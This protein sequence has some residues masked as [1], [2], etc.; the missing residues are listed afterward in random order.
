MDNILL[1]NDATEISTAISETYC[2]LEGNFSGPLN[3][4]SGINDGFLIQKGDKQTGLFV[5]NSYVGY[6][7]NNLLFNYSNTDVCLSLSDTKSFFIGGN[8]S[9]LHLNNLGSVSFGCEIDINYCGI[10]SYAYRPTLA[11]FENSLNLNPSIKFFNKDKENTFLLCQNSNS[12]LLICNPKSISTYSSGYISTYSNGDIFSIGCVANQ[13]FINSGFNFGVYGKSFFNNC[14]S[15]N[16]GITSN[17]INSFCTSYLETGLNVETKSIFYCSVE[18][19]DIISGKTGYF[20]CLLGIENKTGIFSELYIS[21]NTKFSGIT[22][23]YDDVN[24][25]NIYS[26]GNTCLNSG[27]LYYSGSDFT[28]CAT[29]SS[30]VIMGCAITICATGNSS[31]NLNLC[32]CV[33]ACYLNVDN[34]I[35]AKGINSSGEINQFSGCFYSDKSICSKI[36]LFLNYL[37]GK[38]LDTEKIYSTGLICAG[39][40]IC[41]QSNICSNSNVIVVGC[42]ISNNSISGK[43][44][45][46]L[47]DISSNCN[48]YISGNAYFG[49]KLLVNN[50]ICAN[51]DL[52]IGNIYSTGL[53]I[54]GDKICS[55]TG[56]FSFICTSALHVSSLCADSV[57]YQ[58][59]D[60]DNI[61]KA[62]GYFE[63]SGADP[64]NYFK[65]VTGYN[66]KSVDVCRRFVAD[67]PSVTYDVYYIL[68]FNNAIKFPFALTMNFNALTP[69][70]MVC[71]PI[72]ASTLQPYALG[73]N[74]H[75]PSISSLIQSGRKVNGTYETFTIG[76]SYCEICFIGM[77][78]NAA[79]APFSS[80][81]CVSHVTTC[82]YFSAMFDIKSFS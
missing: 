19:N 14:A 17:G 26:T 69:P 15:F 35:Y 20:S 71:T 43:N 74:Y 23:H 44:L 45:Y 31:K 1:A 12:G 42:V 25:L 24:F 40:E 55:K 54:S 2:R 76:N 60:A 16:C 38:C 11:L 66:I 21:G 5:G 61:T 72:F 79:T 29:G 78:G 48:L 59:L 68:K 47:C 28:L 33:N 6:G 32:S 56:C 49:C 18:F 62:W 22:C 9:C 4:C 39:G 7:V 53:I 3:I 37:S 82:R 8:G 58:G 81:A 67:T 36:G 52:C 10:Q 51:G 77:G 75:T 41:A 57:T 73:Q 65:N 50:C 30:N 46:S 70:L 13:D 80:N 27:Y 34:T 64:I 63:Y